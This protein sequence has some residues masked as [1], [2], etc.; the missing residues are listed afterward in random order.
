MSKDYNLR[1]IEEYI[2]SL[3]GEI[4]E[5]FEQ[6]KKATSDIIPV[7]GK[8]LFEKYPDLNSFTWTQSFPSFN[9]GDAC[10]FYVNTDLVILNQGEEDEYE[11]EGYVELDENATWEDRAVSDV[12]QM[13]SRA[14]K[15]KLGYS[16]FKELYGESAEIKVSKGD[17]ITVD[18][19]EYYEGY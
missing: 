14:T 9:D 11:G 8:S 2:D 6:I 7:F 15:S 5:A 18:V 19:N 13:L 12:C 3:S 4:D 1:K 10:E 16:V 17:A